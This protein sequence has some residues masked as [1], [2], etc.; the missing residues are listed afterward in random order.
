M[1]YVMGFRCGIIGLPNVGKSTIFNAL[2]AAGA[3]VANYPFCT[4]DPNVGIVP[5]PDHR[6]DKIAEIIKP[7]KVTH[8]SMEFLDIAGLVK[9]ASRGEGLG[10]KFLGHIRE[11]D[12]VVH[13]VRCFNN[14]SVIHVDGSIDPARDIDTINTELILSDLETLERRITKIDRLA[15]SG[16]KS[17]RRELEICLTL[18]DTLNRGI[19]AR[20]NTL[21]ENEKGVLRDLHLLTAK[22]ILYVVNINESA[23]KENENYVEKVEWI[24]KQEGSK[25][26]VICGDLESEI[27]ELPKEEQKVFLRELGLAE[28]GLQKLIRE[29]YDLLELITFYTTVGPELRAWTIP[30]RTRA[31][32]AAGK[33]HT[34]M[35]RGF[36]RAEIIHFDEFLKIGNMM[37]AKEQGLVRSEGKDYI[38]SDGDIAL[39]RFNI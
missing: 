37:K 28:S 1:G 20:R 23:L 15:K 21:T 13:I 32:V 17:A 36:I 10:N 11:V 34:D 18:Q 33:I 29:G 3:E 2:T 6:L 22:K 31:P 14:P 26:I 35:E 27:T 30:R 19:P 9:G 24:A 38:I 25:V 12:A 4:I 39:F 8:A 7:P 16:D 5:V